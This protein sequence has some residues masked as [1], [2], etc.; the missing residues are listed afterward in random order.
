MHRRPARGNGGASSCELAVVAQASRLW[1]SGHLARIAMRP[2]TAV[3]PLRGAH[4]PSRAHCGAS[5]QCSRPGKVRDGEGATAST[6][7]ACAPQIHARRSFRITNFNPDQTSSTAHT[8]ISTSPIGSATS[9]I[10]SSVMS[11]LTPEDFF[12]QETQI[13]PSGT[14]LV[15]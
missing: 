4:A 5:P 1:G 14:I 3:S 15:R 9:R 7:G 10:V 11:V 13:I 2:A 6:R 8:L 12:G